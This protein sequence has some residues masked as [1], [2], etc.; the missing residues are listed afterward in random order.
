[1]PAL[2]HIIEILKATLDR[3][4]IELVAPKAISCIGNKEIYPSLQITIKSA[5]VNSLT[6]LKAK[7]KLLMQ[8][9]FGKDENT[10]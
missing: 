1:M 2:K 8:I 10:V 3:N 5:K 6:D 9:S 7:L 4:S